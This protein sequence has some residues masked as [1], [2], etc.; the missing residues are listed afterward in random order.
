MQHANALLK[1]GLPCVCDQALRV[2]LYLTSQAL[3][4]TRLL[5]E[6]SCI[7]IGRM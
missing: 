6:Y 5:A 4:S 1:K 2:Y 3:L 7:V